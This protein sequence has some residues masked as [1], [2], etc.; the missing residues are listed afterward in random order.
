VPRSKRNWF[1]VNVR[2]NPL[3]G[4][5][6]PLDGGYELSSRMEAQ[7]DDPALGYLVT[8]VVNAHEGRVVCE[9][10]TVHQRDNG[11][12]VTGSSL[13]AVVVDGY[14]QL[15]I[16]APAVVMKPIERTEESVTYRLLSGEELADVAGRGA[17][18]TADETLPAVVQVYRQALMDADPRVRSSPT[19]TVARRLNY[20]RGHAARLVSQARTRG[21]LGPARRGRAGERQA[22]KVA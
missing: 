6:G 16:G 20:S 3:E 11:P 1:A 4:G 18:R 15:V 19:A 14:V 17:R 2:V 9:S 5:G 10:V 21:L 13:R 22:P 7:V 8:L 12:P